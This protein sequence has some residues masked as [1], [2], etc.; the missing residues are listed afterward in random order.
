MREYIIHLQSRLIESQGEYPQPPPNINLSH[1][2]HTGRHAEHSQPQQH[3]E[4]QHRHEHP[5]PVA[6]M[7]PMN[8][9]QASAAR[10]IAAAGL[11]NSKHGDEITSYETTKRYK[12]TGNNSSDN[13]SAADDEIIR[14]QL[15]QAS[16]DGL[17][18]TMAV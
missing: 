7:A 6:P 13:N 16:H 5:A 11:Q 9:L 17:P 14:S 18:S 10:G 8:P 3:T 12:P 15:Q 2:H 1:P 4:Q